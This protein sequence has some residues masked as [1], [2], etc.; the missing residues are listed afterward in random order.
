M[1]TET[2]I[3]K[4]HGSTFID[5][6]RIRPNPWNKRRELDP[7]FVASIEDQGVLSPILVRP[8]LDAIADYEI[9]CGERRWLAVQKIGFVNIPAVVREMDDQE[10]QLCTLIENTHRENMTPWQEAQLIGDLLARPD[11]D[12]AQAAAATGWPESLIRRRAKLLDLSKS[13]R[14]VLE[15]GKEYQAWSIGHFETLTV[16]DE[17]KQE[18]FFSEWR[19]DSEIKSAT[20][21]QLRREISSTTQVLKGAPWDLADATLCPAAGACTDCPKRTGANA[22]LFEEVDAKVKDGDR[23]L[24]ES[25]FAEKEKALVDR[26]TQE[27]KAKHPDGVRIAKDYGNTEKD[28]YQP[29]QF[30]KAKKSDAGAVAALVTSGAGLGK[31]EYVKPKVSA[32][33][34]QAPAL[35]KKTQTDKVKQKEKQRDALA[36]TKLIAYIGNENLELEDT[37]EAY[38]VMLQYCLVY[39]IH[40][41]NLSK[42]RIYEQNKRVREY[43]AK[44]VDVDELWEAVQADMI[45]KLR[46]VIRGMSVHHEPAIKDE[47]V[48]LCAWMVDADFPAMRKEATTEL[49]DPKSW[50][51]TEAQAEKPKT[52][53]TKHD[54]RGMPVM[55]DADEIPEDGESWDNIEDEEDAE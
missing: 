22:D 44:P 32:S 23:C 47:T 48:K 1:T 36:I 43:D 14:K 51:P 34:E 52:Q 24:D 5:A 33:G 3:T 41:A 4:N 55:A 54:K 25:C 27:F 49:P 21:A 12:I 31:V 46:D 29:H 17:E 2:A 50:T 19:Y 38:P 39:G 18:G 30:E 8:V 11:W 28:V 10:A 20:V 15:E 35:G 53:T 37:E 40:A 42:G 13:W 16:F 6:D 45:D 7:A 26:K 9:I